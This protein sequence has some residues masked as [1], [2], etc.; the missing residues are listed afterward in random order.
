MPVAPVVYRVPIPVP[1]PAPAVPT[2]HLV[3]TRPPFQWDVRAT[4]LPTTLTRDQPA[5]SE[6]AFFPPLASVTLRFITPHGAAFTY[7]VAGAGGAALRVVDVLRAVHAALYM[8]ADRPRDAAVLRAAKVAKGYRALKRD[9][10]LYR[11]DLYPVS[12]NRV[13]RAR[14]YFVGLE[15]GEVEGEVRVMLGSGA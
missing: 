6:P 11:V 3:L 13:D 8:H 2:I 12:P 5:R 15:W 10:G 4:A 7:T 14:L 9:G 1:A